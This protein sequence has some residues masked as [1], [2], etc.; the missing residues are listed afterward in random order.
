MSKAPAAA[1]GAEA[2]AFAGERDE[3]GLADI[4]TW[5]CHPGGP[6]VLAAMAG[7][8]G[9]SDS[10]VAHSWRSLA[11]EGNISS[12]SVLLVLE[13]VLADGTPAG[14]KPM[15]PPVSASRSEARSRCRWSGSK[16]RPSA[17]RASSR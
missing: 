2:A 6:K 8:L 13:R 12:T 9:L 5:V 15:R 14:A 17:S 11:E 3:L 7:G 16:R 4:T 10:D 1:R